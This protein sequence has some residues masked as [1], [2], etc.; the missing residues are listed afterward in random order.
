LKIETEQKLEIVRR[1]LEEK[2]AEEIEVIDLRNRTLIADYFVVCSGTSNTHIK[3]IADGLLT[4]GRGEGLRKEHAEGYAQARWVLVDYGDVVVHI[5]APEERQYY[6][7]ES[8]WKATE[9]RL[10]RE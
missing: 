5:F 4:D 10:E 7:I 8:L 9:A 2:K 1:L 6:D 3:A